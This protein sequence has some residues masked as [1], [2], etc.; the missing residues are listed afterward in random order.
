MEEHHRRKE[1][2]RMTRRTNRKRL[3]FWKAISNLLWAIVGQHNQRVME[4]RQA[5]HE[6]QTALDKLHV[7][8]KRIE[9]MEEQKQG[10]IKRYRQTDENRIN[11]MIR[12][13]KQDKEIELL[14]LKIRLLEQELGVNQDPFTP[15]DY[16]H[17]QKSG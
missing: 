4:A 15:A 11:A 1:D 7:A 2:N 13:E 5:E 10:V 12:Q 16:E 3:S 14:K 6:A 9:L 17:D 8:E